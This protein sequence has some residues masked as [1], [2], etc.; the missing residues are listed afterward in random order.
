M[1]K[2]ISILTVLLLFFVSTTG[3]PLSIHF[4]KMIKKEVNSTCKMQMTEKKMEDMHSTGC[5]NKNEDESVSAKKQNCCKVETIIAGVQ[6]S[7]ISGKTE[8]E[9]NL[10]NQLFPIAEIPVVLIS[11]EI[12]TYSFIDTSPPLQHNNHLYLTNSI[13]LI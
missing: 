6:D 2:K 8:A 3:L 12:S 4:C 5:E 10:T 13:L 9:N 7:F 1:I 11:E